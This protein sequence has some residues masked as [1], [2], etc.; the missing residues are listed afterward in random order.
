MD[1]AVALVSA[2][3]HVNGYFTVPEYPVFEVTEDGGYRTLTDVDI[4]AFRFQGAGRMV[5]VQGGATA[6]A[7]LWVDPDPALDCSRDQ[8]D[9][10][11]VEVKEGRARL[12]ANMT[13]PEV[14]GV[15]LTRFGCCS[16]AEAPLIIEALLKNGQATSSMGHRLRMMIFASEPVQHGQRRCSVI[17][18]AHV[19]RFLWTHLDDH[20]DV[21]HQV[22]SKDPAFGFLSA[23]YK[24]LKADPPSVFDSAREHGAGV[25]R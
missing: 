25:E 9:M 14:L 2:Y 11:I 7:Q 12:N 17:S 6:D 13:R 20:W 15:V 23:L 21:L 5:P 22:Q 16:S 24:A 4:L 3:L 19:T 10:L 8:A 18:L 1:N